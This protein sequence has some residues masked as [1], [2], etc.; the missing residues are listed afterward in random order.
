MTTHPHT[1]HATHRVSRHAPDILA[2]LHRQ[3]TLLARA[4]VDAGHPLQD[5]F[6]GASTHS[7]QIGTGRQDPCRASVVGRR[8]GGASSAASR[9]LGAIAGPILGG[10]GALGA[11]AVFAFGVTWLVHGLGILLGVS[12]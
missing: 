12:R 1:H 10:L 2:A 6:R 11:W 5:R 4:T 8:A 7:S 9:P 3:P